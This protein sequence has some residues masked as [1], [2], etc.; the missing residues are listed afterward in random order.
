MILVKTVLHLDKYLQLFRS[1]PAK[2]GFV[3]TMGALHSGHI[4]LVEE[5]RRDNEVTI[6][7]IFVNPT[8][9]NNPADFEQYPVTIEKD[10]DMLEAAGC[11]LLFMPSAKEMYPA[12]DPVVHYDLGFIETILEGKYRPGH[13]QGVCRIVDKLLKAVKPD[14]LYMGRKDYQQCM[15]VQKL[16]R[17]RQHPTRLQ[18]CDTVRTPEGL[19]MSSRNMR[20][21]VEERTEALHIIKTLV[22]IRAAL[23]P[24]NLKELKEKAVKQLEQ[25]GFI[26]DYVA[27]A[28]A[29]SLQETEEWD[30]HRPLVGLVA[31]F[32]KEVRLIDNLALTVPANA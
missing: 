11:D 9:F 27:I 19:A 22:S 29:D 10:I 15:V 18:V 6:C 17:M 4:S 12:G 8:Q 28:D 31:A 20:L 5:S 30:G 32:L 21:T 26:V 2:I 13:F 23:Q 3:P 7:S 25:N 1:Y 16:I 14:T 24:G